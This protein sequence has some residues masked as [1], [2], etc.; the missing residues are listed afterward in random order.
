[1]IKL[2]MTRFE[3]A[4]DLRVIKTE[5]SGESDSESDSDSNDDCDLNFRYINNKDT[6]DLIKNINDGD[7]DDDY[8]NNEIDDDNINRARESY[9]SNLDISQDT[10]HNSIKTK[11]NGRY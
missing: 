3:L 4:K 10:V 11:I 7:D 2:Y 1:M 6:E 5:L 8:D 9:L